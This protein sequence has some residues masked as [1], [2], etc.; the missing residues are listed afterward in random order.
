[1]PPS[2]EFNGFQSD[3]YYYSPFLILRDETEVLGLLV[4]SVKREIE[5]ELV[6]YFIRRNLHGDPQ[7]TRTEPDVP[8]NYIKRD[9]LTLTIYH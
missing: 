4:P 3:H 1:M 6:F 9:L 2:S 7:L 8:L 5:G